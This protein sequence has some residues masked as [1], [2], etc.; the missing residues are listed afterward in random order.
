M[1]TTKVQWSFIN[2]YRYNIKEKKKKDIY[3]CD[4]KLVFPDIHVIGLP[5]LPPLNKMVRMEKQFK[6]RDIHDVYYCNK[7]SLST[8]Q[9]SSV[10]CHCT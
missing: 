7:I 6:S 9:E 8:T 3:P 10:F 2:S 5:A 4:E 1:I